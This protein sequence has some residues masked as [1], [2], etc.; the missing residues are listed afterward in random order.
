VCVCVP[1]RRYHDAHRVIVKV[2]VC[3]R[4]CVCVCLRREK[5]KETLY[6]AWTVPIYLM[7]SM[8]LSVQGSVKLPQAG[9]YVLIFDNSYSRLTSKRLTFWTDLKA[10]ACLYY[11]Q[12][13]QRESVCVW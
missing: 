7:D 8:C 2:G 4:V 11:V 13:K 12:E 10:G 5:Q 3:V 6:H 9:T 1:V